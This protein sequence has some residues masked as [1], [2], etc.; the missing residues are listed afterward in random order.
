MSLYQVT[1]FLFLFYKFILILPFF[2][3]NNS[4]GTPD[5]LEYVR[6]SE[7]YESTL[8]KTAVEDMK[9]LEDGLEVSV[10]VLD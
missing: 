4:E 10:C 8:H 6:N 1:L 2:Y 9:G 5:Y 3:S 7:R